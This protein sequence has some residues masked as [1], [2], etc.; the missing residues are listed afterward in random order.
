M[1]I[2]NFNNGYLLYE[3]K[4]KNDMVLKLT[5]IG[6]SIVGVFVKDKNNNDVQVS[7]G[8]DDINFYLKLQH[9]S[10]SSTNED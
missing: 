2:K 8:S 5:D 9:S 3:L 1:Q 6:A 4:N 7:F 10:A